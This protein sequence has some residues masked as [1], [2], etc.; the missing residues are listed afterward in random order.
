MTQ[1]LVYGSGGHAKVII[2]AIESEGKYEITG[3]IDDFSGPVEV[4]GYKVLGRYDDMVKLLEQG[5][6]L[7]HVAIG[8]NKQREL[9][10]SLLKEMG[11]GLIS[12]IHPFTSVA[13][14]VSVGEGA[15]ILPG[16]VI[17]PN[18]KVGGGTILNLN[19]LIGHDSEIGSFVH[20]SVQAACGANVTVGDGSFIGMGSTVV[21]GIKIG[22]NAYIG[23]GSLVTKDIPNDVLAFGAPARIVRSNS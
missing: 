5:I 13:R 7:A 19:S 9:K 22:A 23:A 14:N 8:D 16:T 18:V 4:F 6:R 11:F 2:D 1:V 10:A 12:A 15:A 21:S 17:N 3:L 20:L